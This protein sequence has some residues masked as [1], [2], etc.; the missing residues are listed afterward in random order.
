MKALA[1][2]Y[3]W[4]IGLD[5]DIESSRKSYESCAAT[6]PNPAS[7]TLHL[8]VWPDAPWT[9][10]HVDYA[11]PL[12]GKMFLQVVHGHSKWPEVL[13]A[14][15]TMS[16]STMEA[17]LTLFGPYGLPKQLVSDNGPQFTCS[18]F[19]QFLCTNGIKLIRSAP[20]HPSSN[21][22]A[23]RFIQTLKSSLRASE[24]DG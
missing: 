22:Q 9:G 1:C 17:L 7:A 24:N 4:W 5:K 14:R 6:K 2:S 11:V 13:I 15:S 19:I 20:Y 3:F 12:L 18:E 21:W 23:E 10:I 8:W 16:K